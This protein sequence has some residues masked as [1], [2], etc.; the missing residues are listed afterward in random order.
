[1]DVKK[2]IDFDKHI[3]WKKLH[4]NNPYALVLNAKN[5]WCFTEQEDR[6]NY[7]FMKLVIQIMQWILDGDYINKNVLKFFI[8]VFMHIL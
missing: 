5:I 3:K 4:G 2:V 6:E 1:M 7:V 8:I